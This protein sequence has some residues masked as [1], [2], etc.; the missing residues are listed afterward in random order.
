MFNLIILREFN[1]S[2]HQEAE[3]DKV[4]YSLD[5]CISL[6]LYSTANG[7]L[8]SAKEGGLI[9]HTAASNR[10]KVNCE[11]T[12]IQHCTRESI[13]YTCIPK[14]HSHMFFNKMSQRFL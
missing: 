9:S 10:A 2:H 11:I 14:C 12:R 6:G 5:F 13:S 3:K 8:P 1:L 7:P 4:N